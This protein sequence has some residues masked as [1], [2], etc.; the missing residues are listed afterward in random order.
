MLKQ[1]HKINKLLEVLKNHAACEEIISDARLT[2]PDFRTLCEQAEH[3]AGTSEMD[4]IAEWLSAGEITE[5]Q[6]QELCV[7]EHH[8][9]VDLS[10]LEDLEGKLEEADEIIRDID[11]IVGRL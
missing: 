3:I 4:I 5:E 10:E 6:L 8:R 11:R 1:A 7:S 2:Y 9:V